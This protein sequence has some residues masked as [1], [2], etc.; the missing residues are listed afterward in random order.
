MEDTMGVNDSNP[1][2]LV[3]AGS[4]RA[5]SYN[6]KLAKAAASAL[7][8]NGVETTF[9]DLKD[10]PMPLYDGDVEA[11]QGMPERAMAF[12]QLLLSH[13]AFVI[14]SPEYNGSFPALLKNVIDW[15]SRPEPGE[16]PL[17]AYR[18]KTAAILSTSPGPG[19][20]HRG[21][22]HLRELLEM[23]GVHV[24]PE[25]LAMARAS[26]AFDAEGALLRPEDRNAL[27][28]LASD[29]ALALREKGQ[30]AA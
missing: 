15:T 22:R 16:K 30:A 29:L 21:L 12:K 19:G 24:I 26:Q 2:V 27:A 11:A 17:A 13:D 25:Q 23:I 9:A 6:R 14:A 5:D 7:R 10:Y 3:F 8:S 20:G 4:I 1:R 28:R 18:G